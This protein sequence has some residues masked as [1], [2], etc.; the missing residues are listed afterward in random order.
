MQD[1]PITNLETTD[2]I[3]DIY[4]YIYTIEIYIYTIYN[5]RYVLNNIFLFK[6]G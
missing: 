1:S 5:M 4:I 3:G 6:K 2:N